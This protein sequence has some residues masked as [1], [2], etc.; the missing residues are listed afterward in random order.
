[1]DDLML[2]ARIDEKTMLRVS[3]I[4]QETYSEYV[5][6]D[7]LGGSE[8]YF[9]VRTTQCPFS[10]SVEILAKLPNFEAAIAVFDMIVGRQVA[11]P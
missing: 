1:M 11:T 5:D 7:V 3:P 2:S 6:D 9:L 10:P 4:E 8:G